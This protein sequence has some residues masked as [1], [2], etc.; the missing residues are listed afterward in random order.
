[1]YSEHAP[2]RCPQFLAMFSHLNEEDFRLAMSEQLNGS[3]R[4]DPD[5]WF[6]PL[7]SET[8]KKFSLCSDHDPGAN[9]FSQLADCGYYI[10]EKFNK[11]LQQKNIS[12]ANNCLSLLHLNIRSLHRNLNSLIT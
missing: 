8:Y 11:M 7:L 10:E 5:R 3:I 12:G 4:Y 2:L 9:F 6:N 1:M